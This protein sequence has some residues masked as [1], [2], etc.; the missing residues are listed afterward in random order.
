MWQWTTHVN[1]LSRNGT[2][3][4]STAVN[5]ALTAEAADLDTR[6]RTL[7]Q[8]PLRAGILRFLSA[9]PAKAFDVDA[10][11]QPSAACAS[12]S[13]TASASSSTSASPRRSRRPAALHVRAPRPTPT[14]CASLDTFL[15]RRAAV[16]I[17]DQSPSVQRFR[18]MIGRDEKMLVVFEWIR[19]AAKSDI[20]VLI[21]GPTGSGKE[22]VARMIHELSRRSA[23]RV[24]GR[25]LRG[26]ARHAVRVGNLRLREGR[27]HRR[28]RPQAR[29]PRAGQR[30]ARCSSTKSATCRSSRRPSCCACSKSAASSASAAIESI[31]VDFRLISATNRPLDLFVRE[32]RFREDLYYRVNAFAIRL[33]SLR[34][35][36][37]DIPVL[38]N[39]F[40][41]RYCAANGLPLDAK[42]FAPRGRRSAACHTP[43]PATSASSKARCRARRCRRRDGRSAPPT[44][45][46]CTRRAAPSRRTGATAVAARRRARAHHAR[47]RSRALEQERSGAGARHQPR[48]AL[49]EDRGVRLEPQLAEIGRGNLAECLEPITKG[50]YS[51]PGCAVPAHVASTQSLRNWDSRARI[52]ILCATFRHGPGRRAANSRQ[53][54][55]PHSQSKPHR[56]QSVSSI[57]VNVVSRGNALAT[58]ASHARHALQSELVGAGSLSVGAIADGRPPRAH[59]V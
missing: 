53:S 7:V 34:E 57:P 33:P 16:G 8:S 38:A 41:A 23:E 51:R 52:T 22:L 5:D 1:G 18:E 28:A 29:T 32:S 26:A 35:R 31:H 59:N 39:R 56:S 19:T 54:L 42:P 47:A 55:L 20:S 4:D 58:D 13:R 3:A 9:R 11:M 6:F 48:H 17:E 30:A 40:L 15:E 25:E 44:S 49:P 27:V 10:L 24:P 12:T 50:L 45:S 36:P 43:G 37:V 46:S 21:L 2:C 14:R